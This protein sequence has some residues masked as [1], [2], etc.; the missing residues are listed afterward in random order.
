MPEPVMMPTSIMGLLESRKGVPLEV[1]GWLLYGAQSRE[2]IHLWQAGLVDH[3]DLPARWMVR[4][5]SPSRR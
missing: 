2:A 3:L 1:F 5:S 4:T